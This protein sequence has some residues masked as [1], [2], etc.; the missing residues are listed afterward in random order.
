MRKDQDVVDT[1]LGGNVTHVSRVDDAGVVG[2]TRP[3]CL[4]HAQ[5]EPCRI[6]IHI[7]RSRLYLLDPRVARRV[8]W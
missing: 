2:A 1:R 4:R 8:A 6:H 5:W 3:A 7:R